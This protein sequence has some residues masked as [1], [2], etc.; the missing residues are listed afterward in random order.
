LEHGQ[1]KEEITDMM[2]YFI[3]RM[4]EEPIQAVLT[5]KR[6]EQV[7]KTWNSTRCHYPGCTYVHENTAAVDVHVKRAH[8]DMVANI[9][10]LGNFWAAVRTMV[11][12]NRN[13]T[14]A[15]AL[16]EGKVW[17][18]NAEGCGRIFHSDRARRCHFT[19]MHG[20]ETIEGWEAPMRSLTQTWKQ[21]EEEEDGTEAEREAHGNGVEPQSRKDPQGAGADVDS[22]HERIPQ[23]EPPQIQANPDP[24]DQQRHEHE[25][26]HNHEE[27]GRHDH[28]R[29]HNETTHY[30]LIQR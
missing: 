25:H 26:R 22:E 15:E 1:R 19:L 3:T 17:Q 21:R 4:L 20:T 30:G 11:R 8:K 10:A 5:N 13:T 18:S 27:V 9:R 6:G 28:Q 29:G 24:A 12:K 23:E 7:N 14:I 2:Y 16:R